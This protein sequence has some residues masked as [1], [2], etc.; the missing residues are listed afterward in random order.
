MSR[1][2]QLRRARESPGLEL[3]DGANPYVWHVTLTGF[4]GRHG[5]RAVG[6]VQPAVRGRHHRPRL[7]MLVMI[8]AGGTQGSDTLLGHETNCQTLPAEVTVR[9]KGFAVGETMPRP[10]FCP[11]E[12][13]DNSPEN[14]P[15]P[16]PTR[17]CPPPRR[18]P[19][20]RRRKRPRQHRRRPRRQ[21][22]PRGR[23]PRLRRHQRPRRRRRTPRRRARR[24]PSRPRPLRR[25][26]KTP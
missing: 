8:R 18:R 9:A 21:H 1:P 26:L 25:S 16:G 10:D 3:V 24:L 20:R 17:R 19:R 6:P 14:R 11:A 13:G 15:T 12:R 7:G 5:G 23:P 22:P 2:E 4:P